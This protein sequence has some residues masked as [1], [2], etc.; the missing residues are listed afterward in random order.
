MIKQVA[1]KLFC[2]VSRVAKRRCDLCFRYIFA[3]LD[4][5]VSIRGTRN[6]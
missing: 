4:C 2:A 1:E 5:F 6:D 3:D